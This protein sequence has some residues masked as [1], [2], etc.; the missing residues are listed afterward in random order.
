MKRAREGTPIR[1]RACELAQT[2]A[3]ARSLARRLRPGDALCL[4][5]ELGAGKT[6]FVAGLAEH[7]SVAD[8]IASP[9]FTLE[10]RHVLHPPDPGGP[11]LLL[12]CDLY[13]PGED[14]RRDLLPS[15]LEARDEGAILA[16]EWPEAVIEWLEPCLLVRLSLETS[17]PAAPARRIELVDRPPGWPPMAE[18][19]AEW[20]RIA[21][22]GA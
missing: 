22:F 3:L 17:P 10:N 12:H 7:F 9:T 18:V 5:G 11:R 19:R 15:M 14:A 21:E 8:E 13:R 2:R 16:V 1:A 20:E 6:A 4:D